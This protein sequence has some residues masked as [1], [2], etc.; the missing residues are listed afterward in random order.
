MAVEE[1]TV[2]DEEGFVDFDFPLVSTSQ[3]D[4][5]GW[6]FGALGLLDG[7]PIGFDVALGGEWKRQDIDDGAFT[8]FWGAGAI[9]RR[10]TESD[11]FCVLLQDKYELVGSSRA[12][13]DIVETMVV[14]LGVDPRL[15]AEGPI[16]TKMFVEP[17][18]DEAEY[19]EFFL[20]V[21]PE[22][23]VVQ[24]HEKDNEYRPNLVK[25]FCR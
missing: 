4:G 23:R 9:I 3:V 8:V 15:I 2:T 7:T 16:R 22:G 10:G 11:G 14:S 25:A 18:G 13:P 12:M 17:E 6:R 20:N 19:A 24:F 1:I 21:D 5:G